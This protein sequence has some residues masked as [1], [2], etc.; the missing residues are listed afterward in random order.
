MVVIVIAVAF[1]RFDAYFLKP[2]AAL[3]T[4]VGRV[5]PAAESAGNLF[6]RAASY[7]SSLCVELRFTATTD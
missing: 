3:G 5:S 7:N 2:L 4:P 6:V 1:V